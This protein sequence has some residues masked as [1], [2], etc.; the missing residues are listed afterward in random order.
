MFFL[1]L[2]APKQNKQTNPATNK[3]LFHLGEYYL[4]LLND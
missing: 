3:H 1:I 2:Y 4:F